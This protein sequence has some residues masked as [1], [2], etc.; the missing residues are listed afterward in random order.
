M[1]EK[2][3]IIEMVKKVPAWGFVLSMG[4]YFRESSVNLKDSLSNRFFGGDQ[5]QHVYSEDGD[6]K[7]EKLLDD[8][9]ILWFSKN[10]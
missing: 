7:R 4:N 1:F 10:K 8:E 5:L 2:V 6:G 3:E 9:D